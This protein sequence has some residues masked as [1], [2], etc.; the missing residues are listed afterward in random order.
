MGNCLY[1]HTPK[2]HVASKANI[3]SSIRTTRL[4]FMKLTPRYLIHR[5][6]DIRDDYTIISKLG[7]GTYG[8]V[9]LGIHNRTGIERAIKRLSK[10]N[11]E[12]PEK[13]LEEVEILKDLVISI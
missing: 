2:P 7:K 13:M 11:I 6:G 9:Y 4:G 5:K 8:S 1:H 10:K 12:N 3:N